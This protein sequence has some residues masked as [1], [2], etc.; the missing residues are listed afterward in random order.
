LLASAAATTADGGCELLLSQLPAAAGQCLR[1]CAIPHQFDREI[2]AALQPDLAVEEREA[3]YC[4]LE[5]LAL[6]SPRGAMLA[7]HDTAR[8][9]LFNKWLTAEG[10]AFQEA[11][12]RLRA[13]FARQEAGTTGQAQSDT[14]RR[15]MFHWIGADQPAGVAEFE[16]LC[17]A[18]RKAAR[19]SDCASLIALVHEYDAIL[20][21]ASQGALLYHE[22]KLAADRS[23]NDVAERL[24]RTALGNASLR[25]G[26][27][28]KTRNRLGL[29]YSSERRWDD[30]IA[31]LQIARATTPMEP[32][33]LPMIIHDLAVAWRGKGNRERSERLLEEAIAL[34]D[35]GE[36]LLCLATAWNSLG[37]L[38]RSFRDYPRAI[39]S[40]E[41]SLSYLERMN[42]RFRRSA[43]YNNLGDVYAELSDWQKSQKYFE[44]SLEVSRAAADTVGQAKT[45]TNLM[46]V[47]SNSQRK[48]EAISA[49]TTAFQYFLG[50]RDEFNAAA[51]ILRIA[52]IHRSAKR[53][54][55]ALEGYGKAIELYEAAGDK[56]AA[57]D[58]EL[59][60]AT[61]IKPLGLPWWAWVF[62]LLLLLLATAIIVLI[63]RS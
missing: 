4:R 8:K 38:H 7:I 13:F 51:A 10:G 37:T 24:F 6:V 63:A 28:L 62:P 39:G 22:A 33:Q 1:L 2:L 23:D 5:R 25:P 14:L 58:V 47:Y 26:L 30:A 40:Y 35:V 49:G 41:K 43:V 50:L 3:I 60:R 46:R 42:D 48:D 31:E 56:Q 53:V 54:S 11:S 52:K 18:D 16:R 17:R 32:R 27:R 9:Y 55:Q 36:N 34:A 21:G 29:L 44:M 61:L 15:R 12:E 19:L 57:Q 20:T 45:L 59:E